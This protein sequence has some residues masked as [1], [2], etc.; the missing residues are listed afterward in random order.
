MLFVD[1]VARNVL[2]SSG[3]FGV[4]LCLIA[5]CVLQKFYLGTANIAG[6]GACVAV[7]YAFVIIYSMLLDGP[8]YFYIAELWPTHLRAKG[9]SKRHFSAVQYSRV[10]LSFRPISLRLMS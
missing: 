10:L 7:I 2:I 1:R 9:K 8:T 5:E 6:N 3:F 4:S